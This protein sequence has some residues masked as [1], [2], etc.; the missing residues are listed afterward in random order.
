MLS[1]HDVAKEVAKLIEQDYIC[2][3]NRSSREITSFLVADIGTPDIAEQIELLERHITR[4]VKIGPMPTASLVL[5]MEYFLAEVTDK[6]VAKELA[7]GLKRKN[8]TRNFLQAV[9]S[10]MDIRSHWRR[11]KTEHYRWYVEQLMIEA[12]NH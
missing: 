10:N 1:P 7:R 2:Y 11:Y 5:G 9:D 12:Y 3:V 4:Y 8:P 6:D